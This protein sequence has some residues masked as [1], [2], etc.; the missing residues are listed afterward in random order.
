MN[1]NAKIS[2][3]IRDFHEN[4]SVTV[5]HLFSIDEQLNIDVSTTETIDFNGSNSSR[6]RHFGIFRYCY[7]KGE[8]N[9]FACKS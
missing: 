9:L 3:K 6:K 5:S 2:K 7:K 4:F 1:T 8:Q